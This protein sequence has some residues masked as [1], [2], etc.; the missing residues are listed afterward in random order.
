MNLSK[1]LRPLVFCFLITVAFFAC[2]KDNSDNNRTDKSVENMTTLVN[3]QEGA[4]FAFMN[5]MQS[6]NDSL[7]AFIDMV[8]W[9]LQQADVNKAF[10]TN[11]S[12]LRIEYKNGL[13]GF[14][15]A[16]AVDAQGNPYDRGGGGG[17]QGSGNAG[18]T[19]LFKTSSSDHII[20]N[21]KILVFSPVFSPQFDYDQKL[22][23]GKI[24]LE[25]TQVSGVNADLAV[26]NTF[27]DYGLVVI[28]THGLPHGF[29]IQCKVSSFNTPVPPD[30]STFTREEILAM[31]TGVNGLPLDKFQNGELAFT[32]R[33][34][35]HRPTSK[36][37]TTGEVL[38][39]DKYIRNLPQMSN[40]IV[41]GN[42]CYSGFTFDGPQKNNMSEAFKSIGAVAYY[43]YAFSDGSSA[44]APNP[45]AFYMEDSLITNLINGDSTG[46]A[47]LENNITLQDV[48]GR[49]QISTSSGEIEAKLENLNR[50]GLWF[51]P[52]TVPKIYDFAFRHF[53]D[54]RYKYGCGTFTDPR[55]GNVYNLACIGDQ[56]WLAENLRFNAPGSRFYN[57]DPANGA[58]YGRLYKFST[59]MAGAGIVSPTQQG[60][61]G[62]CPEG[63]H[64]PSLKDFAQLRTTLI[65]EN[66][67]T[68]LGT[69]LK[70]RNNAWLSDPTLSSPLRDKSGMAFLPSGAFSYSG[71]SSFFWGEGEEGGIFLA[72][73][74]SSTTPGEV[75]LIYLENS[76]ADIGVD[77]VTPG[78]DMRSCRCV[79]D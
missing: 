43:G 35:Y 76:S 59:M 27:K 32:K 25:A 65:A 60:P 19:N 58:I 18:L 56:T 39:R 14:I 4:A 30:G 36:I 79:Q 69:Q 73:P 40:A 7:D 45:W 29:S 34:Y 9:V 61:R 47:H 48:E 55:D 21:K 74:Y 22:A 66:G 11:A 16:T 6:G 57:D 26:I 33:I 5:S 52:V 17:S 44:I 20:E 70:A 2:K 23:T 75:A 15:V 12:V 41:F 28:N 64:L 78:D 37:S 31:F 51:K 62:I 72:S 3:T 54:P 67:S 50:G 10:I 68:G 77:E 1:T 46:I 49:F 71:G 8:K 13:E 42:Y 24:K 63:W 53:F 38:V